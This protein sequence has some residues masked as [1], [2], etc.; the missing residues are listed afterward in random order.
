MW[1]GVYVRVCVCV[2]MS[3]FVHAF[4]KYIMFIGISVCTYVREKQLCTYG[5]IMYNI[6]CYN[7]HYYNIILCIIL[8][9]GIAM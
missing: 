4:V 2:R 1:V 8:N 3:V 5:P 9:Y 7:I 6:H